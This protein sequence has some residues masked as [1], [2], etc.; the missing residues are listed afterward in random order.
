MEDKLFGTLII[1][2]EK[3]DNISKQITRMLK[4][5]KRLYDDIIY[6]I[7]KY[8]ISGLS[9]SIKLYEKIPSYSIEKNDELI[10]N[11][12]I[13]IIYYNNKWIEYGYW[14]NN[15]KKSI[16]EEDSI[17]N[18]VKKYVKI[19]MSDVINIIFYQYLSNY[20]LSLEEII[21]NI[22][23]QIEKDSIELEKVKS[24]IQEYLITKIKHMLRNMLKL[25]F[26]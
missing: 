12:T 2:F 18:I 23:K 1:E 17:E 3:D 15:I 26:W 6:T 14:S 8:S 9:S 19:D 25:S 10:F 11:H 16:N 13:N 21:D 4:I 22:N 5:D 24:N 20:E 7:K